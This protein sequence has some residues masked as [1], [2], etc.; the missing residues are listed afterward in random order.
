MTLVFPIVYLMQVKVHVQE[1]TCSSTKKKKKQKNASKAWVCEKVMD[2]VKEDPSVRPMEL[3]RR[4][5]DKYKIKVQYTKVFR[6]KGLAMAK[7]FG[8]W[9]DSFDKLYAWKAE[10]EKRSPRS[11][12]VIDHM[13]YDQKKYFIRMFVGLK[14]L[15]DGFLA[16]CRPYLAIDSTHL[17]GKYRGQLATAC[18]ID[19]HNWLYPVVYG[20][21]DSETTES[22]V[23]FME[24]LRDAIGS[25][26]GLAICLDAGKGI[27]T[28][29]EQVFGYAEHRECMRHLVVNFKKKFHGKVFDDHL[30]PAAYSWTPRGFDYHMAAIEE[31]KAA[32]IAYLNKYHTR[33]WSRSKYSTSS[34]V[35]YVTNNLAECFNNWIRKHKGL[36]LFQLMDKIRRKI[37]V[38]FEKRR[39]VARKFQGRRILPSVMKELNDISRGL[40][41]EYERIDDMVAEVSESVALGGKRHV[42]DLAN[43]TCTC[44]AFQVSGK[45]CKHAISFIT[46]IR[47]VTIEDFV[48]DCYSVAKFAAAYAPIL[49][50]LTDMSQWPSVNKEF[51]L[52]PPI[53]RRAP[54]RPK[55]Q[56]HK[57]GAENSKGKGKKGQH[58]CPICKAYGHRW[59]SCKD[60]APE[61]LE[62]YAE[63]AKQ[64]RDKRKKK[65]IT[66]AICTTTDQA[67]DG[68]LPL[69]LCPSENETA[70]ALLSCPS[71]AIEGD[72]AK[73]TSSK[74]TSKSRRS[75]VISAAPDSPAMGTRSKKRAAPNNQAMASR[76]KK[77]L[78]L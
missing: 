61:A 15:C 22:W 34:K 43:R 12:V 20:V 42:T 65:P 21:I 5:H 57:S 71:D 35:D 58:Q 66:K 41:I 33:L 6:G 67:T 10:V 23:W 45:P 38:K 9:D 48:D 28:A 16:G 73:S 77:K 59:Q 7:L 13:E 55:V 31:K 4:L 49:P 51:F 24:K 25:P 63:V 64:K 44:R 3:R 78:K 75:K 37:T 46:G 18:A 56:R 50:G 11:I 72:V 47:G 36:M 62:A 14:P 17:T 2:W 54:G 19:G 32:A 53:L 27:D 52:N 29:I 74:T 30:W 1:H 68:T 39:R 76:S 40:D 70:L 69:L 60:A 8:N 26:P